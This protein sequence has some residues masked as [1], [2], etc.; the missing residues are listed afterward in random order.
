MIQA[1]ASLFTFS[2]TLSALYLAHPLIL[3]PEDLINNINNEVMPEP[4]IDG[5]HGDSGQDCGDKG[6]L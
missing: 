3:L 5:F 1:L 6:E 4:R 2:F